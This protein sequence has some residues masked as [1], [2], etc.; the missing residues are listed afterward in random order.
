MVMQKLNLYVNSQLL[1]RGDFMRIR[2]AR[3]LYINI[4]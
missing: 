4:M 3:F 1:Y 2:G